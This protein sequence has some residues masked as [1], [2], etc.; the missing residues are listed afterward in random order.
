[1][2]SQSNYVQL[3]VVFSVKDCRFYFYLP[4]MYLDDHY[5][6]RYGSPVLHFY[7]N[8]QLKELDYILDTLSRQSTAWKEIFNCF[9]MQYV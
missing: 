7:A 6:V 4:L 2:Q 9:V 8:H 1:M 3:S 5:I